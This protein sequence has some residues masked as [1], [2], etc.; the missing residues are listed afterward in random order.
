MPRG[1]LNINRR[2]IPFVRYVQCN[3]EEN[4][5]LNC[6]TDLSTSEG[7]SGDGGGIGDNDCESV[8]IRCDGQST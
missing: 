1:Y 4:R 7:G 2:A 8:Q 6:N 3:G 5:L